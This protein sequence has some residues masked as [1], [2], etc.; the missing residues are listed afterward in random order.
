MADAW[1]ITKQWALMILQNSNLKKPKHERGHISTHD[2][3]FDAKESVQRATVEA[4]KNDIEQII[5]F[6][7]AADT[8]QPQKQLHKRN[9]FPVR[10]RHESMQPMR[11][12]HRCRENS[13]RR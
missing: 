5:N 6:L 1:P 9:K 11:T 12:P 4:T 7:N 3:R 2:F 10:F 8:I 13:P